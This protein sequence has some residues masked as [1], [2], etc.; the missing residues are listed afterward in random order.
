MPRRILLLITDLKVGGTPTVVRELAVRLREPGRVDVAVACLSPWGPVADQLRAAGVAVTSFGARS[1]AELPAA[2]A[3]LARLVRGGGFDTVFSFLVHANAVAAIARPFCP[4]VRFLQSIQ[5]TQ[6]NPRWHW[7][8]Q[9]LIAPA[10]DAVV[11]P[12]ASA[13]DVARRWAGVPNAVVI[14]N[15]VDL[16]AFEDLYAASAGRPA[17]SPLRVGF[18]GRLDPV[19]RV[20]DLLAAVA[21][22]PDLR[23]D[24]FGDGADRSRVER[25]VDRLGLRPVVMLRGTVAGPRDALAAT[26][27]LVLPSEAEGFGLVLIEAMAAGVPVVATDVPGVR[28]VVAAGRTG[29]LVRP[30]DPAA[31]RAAI[32]QA[33]DPA[34]RR[35]VIP[36][37]RAD[38]AARF[39]WPAVLAAYRRALGVR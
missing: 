37:A 34:W 17:G 16:A 31:L 26:D 29:L 21:G 4:G 25:E 19:K 38:V 33:A 35:R 24:L 6:P 28:D 11:V 7:R 10:A 30:G 23:L 3:K 9:R 13:A 15:A 1:T 20:P 12:S 14:P 18:L 5:T 27:V 32:R 22:E 36:A 2:V 8:V 39:G